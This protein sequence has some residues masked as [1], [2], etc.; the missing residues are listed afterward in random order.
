MGRWRR[1]VALTALAGVSAPALGAEICG[2]AAADVPA[3]RPA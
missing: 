2:M 1:I 3:C